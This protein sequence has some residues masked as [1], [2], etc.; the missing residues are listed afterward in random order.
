M[1]GVVVSTVVIGFTL[2]LMN[3]GLQ[4]F[5]AAAA[6]VGPQRD[7]SRV[8]VQADTHKLPERFAWWARTS[9]DATT[10]IRV[11]GA[12]FDWLDGVA[13][14]QVSLLARHGRSRC[15]GFRELAAPAHRRRRPG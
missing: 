15:S 11:P 9:S 13:G 7:S 3:T 4:E 5:H 6:T 12:E 10:A 2:N 8:T 14:R 1:I